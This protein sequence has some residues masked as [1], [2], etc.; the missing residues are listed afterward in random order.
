MLT[1]RRTFRP[2]AGVVVSDFS[3]LSRLR[4]DR[5]G[6]W[7]VS[8]TPDEERHLWRIVEVN[9]TNDL[10]HIAVGR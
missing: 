5:P 2:L 10:Q 7:I 1:R 6:D 4:E 8:R 3:T 9:G